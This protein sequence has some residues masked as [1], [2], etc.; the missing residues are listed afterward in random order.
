MEVEGRKAELSQGEVM[1]RWMGAWGLMVLAAVGLFGCQE[2]GE[3][4]EVVPFKTECLGEGARL[5]MLG[6]QDGKD[7]G[8]F[9]EEIEGFT[10]RWGTIQKVR[11]SKHE[12][13]DP[14]QDASSIRY[15]LEE[16]IETRQVP[17]DARFSLYIT[18][19]YLTGNR[20]SGY[21]LIDST[22][23]TCASSAVCD[24]LEQKLSSPNKFVLNM[25]YPAIEGDPLIIQSVD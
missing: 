5:C 17:E 13:V 25:R 15:V 9:F 11:V 12:V 4:Y 21:S 20:M 3:L 19:D 6:L 16:V 2:E 14:P 1:Q 23:V 7:V 22:R 8:T 10:F 18:R 24:A